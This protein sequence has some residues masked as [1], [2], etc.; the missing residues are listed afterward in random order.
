[1]RR[2]EGLAG[3]SL[4]L[5]LGDRVG[6][7]VVHEGAD[8]LEYL[9][10][11]V[12]SFRKNLRMASLIRPA[13]AEE[14]LAPQ[15]VQF[16][17]EPSMEKVAPVLRHGFLAPAWPR[18]AKR[19]SPLRRRSAAPAPSNV[20]QTRRKL[21]PAGEQLELAVGDLPPRGAPVSLVLS[22]LLLRIL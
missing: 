5:R 7:A 4:D 14:G 3:R 8:L 21:C 20:D 1:M 11:F 16:S 6:E 17:G 22:A 19:V 18:R 15:L 10:R 12:S 9:P 13:V 2:R